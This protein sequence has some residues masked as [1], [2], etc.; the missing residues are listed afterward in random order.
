MSAD[1]YVNW[2]AQWIPQVREGSKWM[3]RAV[4]NIQAPFLELKDLI[5]HHAGD[6]QNDYQ[7]LF[8]DYKTAGGAKELDELRRNWGGDALNAFMY[9]R[10]AQNNPVDLLGAIYI[11]EGT[12]S[13]II[14]SALP[15]LKE[16]LEL[17]PK[18]FKF[19]QYHGENDGHHLARWLKAVEITLM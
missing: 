18:A 14:P 13:R 5:E 12:G 16:Q 11:I 17:P 19:L 10:A 4:S 15:F 9:D 6:E 7:I 8:E 3:R 1:D 2:L